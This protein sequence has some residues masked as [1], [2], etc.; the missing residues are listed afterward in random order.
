MASFTL[1]TLMSTYPILTAYSVLECLLR[2][3][4][5]IL[6]SILILNKTAT[7]LMT[8]SIFWKTIEI[9]RLADD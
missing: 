4:Q 7:N 2:K 5:L 9:L 1:I 6:M 8:M 3:I